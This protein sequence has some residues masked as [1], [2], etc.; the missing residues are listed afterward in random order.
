[1]CKELSIAKSGMTSRC[2]L[3]RAAGASRSIFLVFIH[4]KYKI[5][6]AVGGVGMWQDL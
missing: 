4:Y 1:M 5:V 2:P 3:S 6:V